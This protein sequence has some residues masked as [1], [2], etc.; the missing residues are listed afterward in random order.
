MK[1][2]SSSLSLTSTLNGSGLFMPHPGRFTSGKS[3]RYPMYGRVVGLRASLDGYG[4]SCPHRDSIPG[5]SS[6]QS[7]YGLRYVS[8]VLNLILLKMLFG[9]AADH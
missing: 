8:N 7:L 6:R 5:L 2:D 9:I 1:K 3:S 4:K